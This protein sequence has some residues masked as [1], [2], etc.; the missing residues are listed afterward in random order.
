MI[1]YELDCAVEI[2][3]TLANSWFSIVTVQENLKC[4]KIGAF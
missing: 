2:D 4:S 3:W 1:V